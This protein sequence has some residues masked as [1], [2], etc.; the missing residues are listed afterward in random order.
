MRIKAKALHHTQK[1]GDHM[2]EAIDF[3]ANDV[4]AANGS[5]QVGSDI[6]N[7]VPTNF[8]CEQSTCTGTCNLHSQD[9]NGGTLYWCTCD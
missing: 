5:C 3:T 6:V 9:Q 7:G 4:V 8:R 1:N 2:L